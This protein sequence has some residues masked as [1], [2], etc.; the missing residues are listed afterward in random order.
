MTGDCGSRSRM[1]PL[2]ALGRAIRGEALAVLLGVRIERSGERATFG[3]AMLLA[4][5]LGADGEAPPR[6][7]LM[8]EGIAEWA[9]RHGQPVSA[10][11]NRAILHELVHH[12][13][14]R[15]R[16]C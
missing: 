7:V 13:V 4:E 1:E 6:V 8:A 2:A 12:V 5:Y 10:V 3:E 16:G 15:T 9:R 11:E 14:Q